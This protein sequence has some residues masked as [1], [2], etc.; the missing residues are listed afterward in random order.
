MEKQ[1]DGKRIQTLLLKVNFSKGTSRCSCVQFTLDINLF[2]LIF[3][4]RLGGRC[5]LFCILLITF[6]WQTLTIRSTC[7]FGFDYPCVDCYRRWASASSPLWVCSNW[8][9]DLN[10]CHQPRGTKRNLKKKVLL[11]LSDYDYGWDFH[12]DT[13]FIN[14][15]IEWWLWMFYSY[16]HCY[17]LYLA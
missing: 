16:K 4:H 6:K 15:M 12:S 8:T 17:K 3:N 5:L 9:G 2:I 10:I 14:E 1:D 7:V 11:K 13:L